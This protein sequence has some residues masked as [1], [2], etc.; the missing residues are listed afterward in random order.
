MDDSKPKR[1]YVMTPEHRAKVIAN[2]GQ[3]RLAP[4]EKV[5]RKTEK[6]YQANLNNLGIANAKRIQEAQR[7]AEALRAKMEAL[8]PPPEVPPP[9]IDFSI[10]SIFRDEPPSAPPSSP[11]PS[12]VDEFEQVTPLVAKRLRKIHAARRREGRRI[13]R[14]LAA[15]TKRSQPMTAGEAVALAAELIRCLD[16]SRVTEETRRLNDKIRDLLAKMIETRYGPEAQVGGFPFVTYFEQVQK[17]QRQQD[18]ERRARRE[19]RKAQ[20]RSGSGVRGSGFGEKTPPTSNAEFSNSS[21]SANPESQ[22]PNPASPEPSTISV[23]PL[24]QTLEEFQAL[25]T[26][27]LRLENQPNL[28]L[29]LARAIWVR[30]AVWERQKEQENKGLEQLFQEGAAGEL[31][32]AADP[33]EEIRNRASAIPRVLDL[34]DKFLRRLK[35][36]TAEVKTGLEWWTRNVWLAE[37]EMARSPETPPRKP[38]V[39][40]SS[41]EMTESAEPPAV[42]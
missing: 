17:E 22:N 35:E 16:G 28:A 13:M 7:E 25:V 29:A 32:A 2:L 1:K 19:A 15:A 4:R 21:S 10:P 6:R 3:A 24:P 42:A 26:R 14:L 30:L 11:S 33:F 34:D 41:E 23:P 37:E 12:G 27:A 18:A 9:P 5:Y 8:F 38:P 36:L 20:E 31:G 39:E 40:V